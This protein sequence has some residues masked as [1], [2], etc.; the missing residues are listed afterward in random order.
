MTIVEMQNELKELERK[1]EE[2]GKEEG[3]EYCIIGATEDA[4]NVM[5]DKANQLKK[6]IHKKQTEEMKKQLEKDMKENGME[7]MLGKIEFY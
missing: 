3:Q 1:I 2:W 5:I 7:H 6:D 4:L